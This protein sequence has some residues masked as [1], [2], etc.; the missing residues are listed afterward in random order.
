[1]K[2][3]FIVPFFSSIAKKSVKEEKEKICL[4]Q[5]SFFM[6]QMQIEN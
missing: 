5:N 2:E 4:K 3:F 6:F 1:M